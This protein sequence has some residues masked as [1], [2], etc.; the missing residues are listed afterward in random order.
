MSLSFFSLRFIITNQDRAEIFSGTSGR[1]VTADDEL[2]FVHAL[3]LDPGAAAPSRFVNGVAQL[4]DEA[5]E[6]ASFHFRQ[7]R[8]C[9][10]TQLA[11]VTDR[12]SYSFADF[13]QQFF[14]LNK[15]EFNQTSAVKLKQIEDVI[16]HRSFPLFRL[17]CLQKLE[18]GAPLFVE[19]HN[20]AIDHAFLDRQFL[21]RSGDFWKS[22]PQLISISRD[23][24]DLASV[25]HGNRANAVKLELVNPIAGRSR[26]I[27][28][29]R[30]HRLDESRL[31]AREG[32]GPRIQVIGT[33]RWRSG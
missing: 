28:Q 13:C 30:L 3:E 1:R 11:G 14:A 5:F 4:A 20:F 27:E 26:F 22:G 17:E 16:A 2:L 24:T 25:L 23:Q 29:S 8:F 32:G 33:C 6:P 21:N 19:R 9:F 15:R 18:R 10:A 12:I 7:E 31:C